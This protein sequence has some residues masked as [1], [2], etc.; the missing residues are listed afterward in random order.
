MPP[1]P[2]PPPPGY[3]SP[4]GGPAARPPFSATDALG[5]GWRGFSGNIG[6]ILIIALVI[7]AINIVTNWFGFIA[8]DSTILNLVVQL[9]GWF[10]SLVIS[11][12][13]IRAALAIVDGRSPELNDLLSTNN[14]VTYFVASLLAGLIVA[15]GFLLCIIPGLIAIFLLQFF[16][17]AI[18]DG[19]TSDPIEALKISYGLVS[20]N[21]GE[22]LLFG[23][24]VFLVNL[25]GALLCGIG[26]LV[27]LP[28]TAIAIAYTWRYFSQGM[29]APRA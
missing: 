26:L 9:I 4:M 3:Q 23:I 21:L 22:L 8:G 27:T 12:G 2:P 17:Y 13:L 19:R 15:V 20:K 16:G 28:L 25:V 11:I 5:Y 18:V 10:V 7:V 6:P 14:L 29:I 1:P 24:L